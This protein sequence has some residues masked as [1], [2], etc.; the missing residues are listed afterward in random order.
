[1]NE[2]HTV[3]TE[4]CPVCGSD[5]LVLKSSG[6]LNQG[7]GDYYMETTTTCS[8]CGWEDLSKRETR[9]L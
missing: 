8:E 4:K 1:M 3:D 2:L 5:K 6:T 9:K 7:T